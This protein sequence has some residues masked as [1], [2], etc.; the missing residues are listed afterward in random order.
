MEDCLS[1]REVYIRDNLGNN[2]DPNQGVTQGSWA[3]HYSNYI[4][5][6]YSK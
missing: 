1:D 4:H 5:V 2:I 6:Q 3:K